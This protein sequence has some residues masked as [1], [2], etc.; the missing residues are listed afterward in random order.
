[1]SAALSMPARLA[2]SAL[3]SA[4]D[5]I[6][7]T[8]E[9]GT[10]MFANRQVQALFG[11]TSGEILDRPIEDLLPQRFRDRHRAHR[12]HFM[13]GPRWRPMGAGLELYG[14]RKDEREFPVEISLSPIEDGDRLLVAAAIRDT[15]DRRRIQSEL[16][17]ARETADRANLAKS[18]FLAMASHDLRQPLQTLAL[19]NGALRRITPDAVLGEVLTQQ[20][21]AIGSMLRL[22]NALLDIS[23]LEAGVVRPQSADFS[24]ATVLEELRREFAGVASDK[25]LELRVEPCADIVRSDPALV[26]QILRNLVS[27]AVKYT[28][29]GVVSLRCLQQPAAV[30]IEVLDTGVGIAPEEIP[31][32]FEEFYQAESGQ[33][34]EREGCGLGLSIVSR[35][36][37]LLGL[38]LD[39]RSQ[40]GRGSSFLLRLPL[41]PVRGAPVE[42]K[43]VS[44]TPAPRTSSPRRV[45]LVEDN[46]GV[47]RA[48]QMLL[49]REGYAVVTAAS[50]EEALRVATAEPFDLLI[51]DYHLGG[52]RSGLDVIEDLRARFGAALKLILMSGDTS[53][54]MRVLQADS[55]LRFASKPIRTHQ[56]LEI[57][58]ELFAELDAP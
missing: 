6:V 24:V 5:A 44:A 51:T 36:A 58:G 52:G 49:D 10:I 22:V 14:L 27:N 35:L 15:T 4:P 32:I 56:L 43:P 3:E 33:P 16:V 40:L 53:S 1:M 54:A 17:T 2:Q 50:A 34:A 13:H 11:Y 23:K 25:G 28:R 38:G 21:Q 31:Y 37:R 9:S 26:R 47:R 8:D 41:C 46:A 29:Q 12:S 30:Q 19:L 57:I 45:L 18:R 7:V 48:M 39:V 20:D 42:P 55:A